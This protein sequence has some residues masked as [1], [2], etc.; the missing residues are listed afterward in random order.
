MDKEDIDYYKR[1]IGKHEYEE[2][3][4]EDDKTSE[5]EDED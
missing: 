2:D 1:N 5:F 4:E 3:S